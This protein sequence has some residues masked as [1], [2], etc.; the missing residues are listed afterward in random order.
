MSPFTLV[1]GDYR[2]D[3]M[4][5]GGNVSPITEV[6]WGVGAGKGSFDLGYFLSNSLTTE[7]LLRRGRALTKLY[8]KTLVEY[9]VKDYSLRQLKNDCRERFAELSIVMISA[10]A[11]ADRMDMDKISIRDDEPSFIK[12]AKILLSCI[13]KNNRLKNPNLSEKLKVIGYS[14]Q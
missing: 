4:F 6:D 10:Q 2:L 5:F 12:D 14:L 3:N 13:I 9:G 11:I 1:H 8:H 7:Q